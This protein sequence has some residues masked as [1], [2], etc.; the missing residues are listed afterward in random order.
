MGLVPKVC[1]WPQVPLWRVGVEGCLC[2][3]RK[4]LLS[5]H[6][7]L[8]TPACSWKWDPCQSLYPFISVT[9][10]PKKGGKWR[11]A[12][13][14]FPLGKLDVCKDIGPIAFLLL[15]YAG[16]CES[17]GFPLASIHCSF[18]TISESFSRPFVSLRESFWNKTGRIDRKRHQTHLTEKEWLSEAWS[19]SGVKFPL[20]SSAFCL[21]FFPGIRKH[22]PPFG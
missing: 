11:F 12:P 6:F 9:E 21:S 19:L 3:P 22:V 14:P 5:G 4:H 15:L 7:C 10:I 16:E 17:L 20:T 8:G 1:V 13:L 18:F 2:Q